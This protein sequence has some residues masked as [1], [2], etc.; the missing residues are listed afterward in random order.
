MADG[1]ASIAN[2][3]RDVEVLGIPLGEAVLGGGSALIVSELTDAIITPRLP[4]VPVAAL[5]A[6]EAFVVSRWGHRVVGAGGARIATLF[7]TYE[8]I[9]ALIPLDDWIKQ[10]IER[11]TGSIGGGGGVETTSSSESSPS[12]TGGNGRV[13]GMDAM[14]MAVL[15]GGGQ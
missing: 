5:K 13:D 15:Q 12:S 10:L 6:G 9:R 3:I 2:K 11:I 14:R 4:N 1:I 8:A 7:L